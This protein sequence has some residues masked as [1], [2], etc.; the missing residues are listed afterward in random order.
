MQYDGANWIEIGPRGNSGIR[1]AV[2]GDRI[3]IKDEGIIYRFNGTSWVAD[4]AG[5]RANHCFHVYN[6]LQNSAGVNQTSDGAGGTY[7]DN[8]A[9]KW[10]WQY[11]PLDAVGA[12]PVVTTVGYYS[13]GAW[14]NLSFPFPETGHNSQTIGSI[15]GGNTTDKQPATLNSDN[16]IY[17]AGGSV[18]F[19]N[20]DSR[21][22]YPLTGVEFMVKM[23]WFV[24]LP[25]S[26]DTTVPFEADFK[27]RV[28]FYD[29][30]G[31]VVFADFTIPRL[32][33]WYLI[34]K[35]FSEFQIYRAR[36]PLS[37]GEIASNLIVPELE[38][39][40]V[41]D[42][43]NV[44]LM[45]IQW[46]EAYD[47]EGRF[48]PEGGRILTAP[49]NV[50][51]F[52]PGSVTNV[53]LYLDAFHFTKQGFRLSGTDATRPQFAFLENPAISNTFQLQNA[54]DAQAEI[55]RFELRGFDIDMEL[56]CDIDA[57]DSFYLVDPELIPDNDDGTGGIKLVATDIDITIN[58]S[59]GRGG[60]HTKVRAVKRLNG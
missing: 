47:E 18:G 3:A 54:A 15:F 22:L 16:L 10:I 57:D 25:V 38:I 34:R 2:T 29:L 36:T 6:D 26:G 23:E 20:S 4:S 31:N 7:G 60:A 56:R 5:Q 28:Y 51:S 24:S 45:V 52:I 13:M 21:D 19:N 1:A 44:K 42:W 37:L 32:G 49:L 55:E 9:K 59:Q 58:A 53:E 11:T 17:T 8:S 12:T 27:Y 46:Q 41:F 39:L 14:A 50:G 43:K 40:D 35:K 30:S 48:K 33:D